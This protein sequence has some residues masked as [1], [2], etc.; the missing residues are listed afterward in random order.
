MSAMTHLSAIIELERHPIENEK[1]SLMVVVRDF[2]LRENITAKEQLEN[3]LKED[4]NPLYDRQIEL[5][6]SIKR[7]VRNFFQHKDSF[8]LCRPVGDDDL[9]FELH[10]MPFDDLSEKFKKKF[11]EFSNVINSRLQAKEINSVPFNGTRLAE[12]LKIIVNAIN[13]NEII[14]MYNTM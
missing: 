7:N 12:Y 14:N 10:T 2:S 9:I 6:N 5:K 11:K 13:K 1:P 8:R 3:F 4:D